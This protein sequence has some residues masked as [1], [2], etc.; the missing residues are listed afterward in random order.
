MNSFTWLHAVYSSSSLSFI[1]FNI[2]LGVH[3]RH[4]HS[5]ARMVRSMRGY[6]IL[7]VVI[8][9]GPLQIAFFTYMVFTFVLFLQQIF[10]INLDMHII[11]AFPYKLCI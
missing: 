7:A 6:L 8:K 4:S 10:Q 2:S 3:F 5:L 9:L 1:T 11:P